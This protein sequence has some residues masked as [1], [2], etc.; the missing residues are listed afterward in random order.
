M[1]SDN[2]VTSKILGCGHD[3]GEFA[4]PYGP[5]VEETDDLPARAC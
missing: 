2:E 1:L 5:V 4:M 3:L